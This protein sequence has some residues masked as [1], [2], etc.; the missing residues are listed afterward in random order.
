MSKIVLLDAGPLGIISNPLHSPQNLACH[1]WAKERLFSG[2]QV[3]IS[4]IADYEVRREL[5]RAKKT[6]SLSRLD[7]LKSALSYLPI[8]TNVMLRAAAFWAEAR[9]MGKPTASDLA[10]DSDMILAAQAQLLIDDGDSVIVA[11]TN[12]AHLAL[13]IPASHWQDIN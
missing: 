8:T 7:D 2:T 11:T 12:V 9:N 4:E 13:F 3:V 5:L 6:R 1:Q 10:L